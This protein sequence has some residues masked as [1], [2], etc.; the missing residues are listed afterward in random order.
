[1]EPASI[2]RYQF[3]TQPVSGLSSVS[4][5]SFHLTH[6]DDML[7]LHVTAEAIDGHVAV[8]VR[9]STASAV[10]V[11]LVGSDEDKMIRKNVRLGYRIDGCNQ[12]VEDFGTTSSV[13][14][15]LGERVGIVA[16]VV[17]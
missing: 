10:S 1:M 14:A 5:D 2:H 7:G 8:Y 9:C 16:F 4:S 13:L 6:A 3:G 17:G 15:L 12:G 11:A